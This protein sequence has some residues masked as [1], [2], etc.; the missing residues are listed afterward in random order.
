MSR[1]PFGLHP[2]YGLPNEVRINILSTALI[3]S[4][5]FAAQVHQV[6]QSAIYRWK[7]ILRD[8]NQLAL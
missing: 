4:V 1:Q 3:T 8:T 6:S 5:A 2:D 7:K